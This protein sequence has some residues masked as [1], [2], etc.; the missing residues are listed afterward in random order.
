LGRRDAGHTG[1]TY[2]S[3][4][5]KVVSGD[6]SSPKSHQKARLSF[7]GQLLGGK[8]GENGEE[9]RKR[10]QKRSSGKRTLPV[11]PSTAGRK[12]SEELDDT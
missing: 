3:K 10:L 4:G 6:L 8:K 12:M 2:N 9:T 7:Q 1:L 5:V 11:Q